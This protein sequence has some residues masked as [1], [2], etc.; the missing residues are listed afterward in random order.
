M[1]DWA[2]LGALVALWGSSFLLIKIALK[3]LPPVTLVAV[4]LSIAAALLTVWLRWQGKRLPRSGRA[5]G[6][7]IAIAI[8]GNC[9]PFV[10]ISWGELWLDS[11]LAGIL[12]AIMPLT[13]L[14]LAHFFVPGERLNAAR[15]GGF[16]L[17]FAGILALL[18]PEAWR[19]FN[20]S[21]WLLPAQLAV[22]AGAVCYAVNTIIARRRPAGDALTAAA[23]V[24]LVAAALMP[25]LALALEQP[26]SLTLSTD[27]LLAVGAL[28]V[29]STA[30]AT[31]FYFQLIASAGPTFLAQINYLIPLWAV[32]VG[33]LFLGERLR[34]NALLA[35]ALI[36]AGIALAR[37]R[38]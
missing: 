27:A 7:F 22:L 4:R 11:S 17:G 33:A 16:G 10:L 13:T 30:L 38:S 24:N 20:G 29:A 9:A 34:W 1:R 26:W 28:G 37:R 2:L 6:F 32:A 8:V 18:G 23:G 25:P 19:A 21:G 15:L 5:W 14:V 3:A 36:L 35:L 12:M 31:V